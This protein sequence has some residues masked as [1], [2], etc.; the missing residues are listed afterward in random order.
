LL[1]HRRSGGSR[2]RLAPWLAARSELSAAETG[3]LAACSRRPQGAGRES[4]DDLNPFELGLGG[5]GQVLNKAAYRGQKPWQARH[6]DGVPKTTS[7]DAGFWCPTRACGAA[8]GLA[9]RPEPSFNDATAKRAGRVTPASG[10]PGPVADQP[11]A[12][13]AW[14]L[15]SRQALGAR[16]LLVAAIRRGHHQKNRW[17]S[18]PAVGSAPH[19]WVPGS[20]RQPL[21]PES[22]A[23]GHRQVARQSVAVV[24]QDPHARLVTAA[25]TG[26]AAIAAPLRHQSR[27]RAPSTPLLAPGKPARSPRPEPGS[28]SP[29]SANDGARRLCRSNMRRRSA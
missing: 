11:G 12:G 27:Q 9:L 16:A 20:C 15:G 7:S 17:R 26:V 8:S 4:I 2:P 13:S 28:C 22:A 14:A 3:A 24:A 10:W 25:A 23:S 1:L 29:A 19:R 6:Y 21:D 5:A 18:R